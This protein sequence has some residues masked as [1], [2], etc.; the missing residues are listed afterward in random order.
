MDILMLCCNKAKL[1]TWIVQLTTYF[2]IWLF[3]EVILNLCWIEIERKFTIY[4]SLLIDLFIRVKINCFLLILYICFFF[5]WYAIIA[6]FIE[7]SNV[8]SWGF[9]IC[10]CFCNIFVTLCKETFMVELFSNDI[11]QK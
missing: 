7:C 10:G 4:G 2:N 9:L 8:K 11:V 1:T 3:M 6:C 5:T